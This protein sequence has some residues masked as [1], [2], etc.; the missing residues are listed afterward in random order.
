MLTGRRLP[1]Y[2][3]GDRIGYIPFDPSLINVVINLIAPY[4]LQNQLTGLTTPETAV[5]IVFIDQQRNPII[6]VKYPSLSTNINYDIE[7]I[8]L[9]VN[10][11]FAKESTIPKGRGRKPDT[12]TKEK[13]ENLNKE[14]IYQELTSSFGHPPIYGLSYNPMD[15]STSYSMTTRFIKSSGMTTTQDGNFAIVDNR[16][17][18]DLRTIRSWRDCTDFT[19]LDLYSILRDLNVRPPK[20]NQSL[21]NDFIE[22]LELSKI[23]QGREN[24]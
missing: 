19:L 4:I 22:S 20:I 15:Y 18:T 17:F 3:H 24:I 7:Q 10:D 6:I 14:I 23:S 5:N 1:I 21:I 13:E 11:Q 16:N 12:R 8:V 9:I 2:Y